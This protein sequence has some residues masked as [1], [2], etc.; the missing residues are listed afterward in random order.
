[1]SKEQKKARELVVFGTLQYV[2]LPVLCGFL[3][4]GILSFAGL[5]KLGLDIFDFTNFPTIKIQT[6]IWTN[7]S[8]LELSAGLGCVI[9]MILSRFLRFGARLGHFDFISPPVS[10]DAIPVPSVTSFI[11]SII[12]VVGIPTIIVLAA[13]TTLKLVEAG[14]L[15]GVNVDRKSRLFEV[16][17]TGV[18]VVASFGCLLMFVYDMALSMLLRM[19]RR[20]EVELKELG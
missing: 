19:T 16:T 5:E 15:P 18:V 20:K 7:Y 10:L 2:F 14:V 11:K 1:V 17:L 9:G 4:A 6:A 3:T 12:R 8:G 13:V